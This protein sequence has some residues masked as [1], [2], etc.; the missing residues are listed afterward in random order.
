MILLPYEAGSGASEW[1]LW[2]TLS[3][4]SHSASP[5]VA[6]TSFRLARN[7]SADPVLLHDIII[8]RPMPLTPGTRLGPYEILA[9]IGAG[10]MGEVWKARDTR[11]DRT[12]AV[13]VLPAEIGSDSD[14]QRR[15]EREARSVAALSHPN[16]VAIYDVGVQ[17]GVAFLVEELIEG[18][19]LRAL[20]EHGELTL[21]RTLALAGQVADAL[22]AAH[23]NGIIH[24]DLKPDNIMVTGPASGYAGRVKILDFGLAR[25]TG[26]FAEDA[27]G[28]TRT[29]SVTQEGAI[30]GTLGYMSPEQV[31]GRT[32]DAR[33]D[34]FSFGAVF[35]EMLAGKRAFHGNSAADVLSAILKEDTAELAQ[36]VPAGV[37]RVVQHC[38]EKDP[39]SRFQSAQDLAFAIQTLSGSSV[40]TSSHAVT[41]ASTWRSKSWL[42]ASAVSVGVLAA[43]FL[44]A[45]VAAVPAI[46]F[47][48]Q[49][50]T[51]LVSES[52]ALMVPRWAPDGKS[53]TYTSLSQLL[54]Q[55]VDAATATVLHSIRPGDLVTPF[56]SPDGSRV[57]YTA[58]SDN[59]SVWSIGVA[60]GEPQPEIRKLGGFVALDGAEL[61]RDGKSL[62][63]AKEVDGVTT[64][65]ISS[66]PGSP[67]RPLPGAPVVNATYSRVRL[68]FSHDGGKLLAVLVG[69]RRAQDAGIWVMPW[70]PGKGAARKID[71]SPLSGRAIYSADW[72]LD[73]RYLVVNEG[74]VDLTLTGGA[75]LLV[76]S[77]SNSAWPLIPNNSYAAYPSVGPDGRILY[78][79]LYAPYDLVETPVDGSPHRELLAKDWIECF[80]AWSRAAD[81]FVYVSDRGGQ[82]AVWI[83]SADGS[84]QRKAVTSKD[85]GEASSTSFRSPE[86]SPDGTHIAYTGGRRVWVSP[87]SGGRPI[88]VTPAEQVAATPTWS[89]DGKW[90]AYRAGEALMKVEVGRSAPP[91][92]IAQTT[93]VPA[94]WSPDG[95]WITAGVDGGIGVLSP[96]GDQKRVLFKRPFQPFASLG[97][98]RDGATVF[99]MEGGVGAPVR[100]SA[101]DVAKGEERLIHEYPADTN[102]Y[103]ELY[104]YSA[105]LYPSR[106]GK[107]LLG[108]RWTVRS[109][110][111][112]LEGV[113]PPRSLWRRLL[114]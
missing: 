59:R 109:S 34:I 49:Q 113:E 45:R 72:L 28:R 33:S 86:F 74:T 26:A 65:Q 66:P 12:V 77:Q 88:P 52:A 100:L 3:L 112:L 105:R 57:W 2:S 76:D 32:V 19:P 44:G 54:I 53:F 30:L 6:P 85:I 78:V 40:S 18:E 27:D 99:L 91:L 46:D 58:M 55:N 94:A 83:S 96:E 23:Q 31:R 104:L 22:S 37:R 75:M 79:R 63:V 60:G 43:M 71:S 56:F 103:A 101:A 35:Y 62:V 97:W 64:L 4:G 82:S 29:M 90:I 25:Q 69:P 106:D 15:F 8:R 16:I 89:A 17:D 95:K 13:K 107:Y 24:R 111:W 73:D 11:L 38:L 14:R 21:H 47:S 114:K 36:S 108:S 41:P 92:K 93:A 61:S 102:T 9:P 7:S 110:I 68:R 51:L 1:A 84:W 98:S 48:N 67:L 5:A 81:E 20:I 10:G 80:G 70:P 42:V 39:S 87:T 50:Y